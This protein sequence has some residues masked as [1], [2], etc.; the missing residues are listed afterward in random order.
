[1]TAVQNIRPNFEAVGLL[2]TSIV[3]WN[4][5]TIQFYAQ[6]CLISKFDRPLSTFSQ[7][8]WTSQNRYP[9]TAAFTTVSPTQFL[10]FG[11]IVGIV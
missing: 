11:K 9:Q 3:W 8:L 4:I 10:G 6:D 1:M 5:I 7:L 2:L